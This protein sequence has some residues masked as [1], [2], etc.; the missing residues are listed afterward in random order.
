MEIIISRDKEK[1]RC[2]L[3]SGSGNYRYIYL[4]E[5][6]RDTG[7]LLDRRDFK[8]IKID[9][10]DEAFKEKFVEAYIDLIGKL[11]LEHSSVYWWVTNTAAKNQFASNFFNNLF[12]FY[13]LATKLD[14]N[15]ETDILIINPP[16]EICGSIKK[17]CRSNSINFKILDSRPPHIF[18][19]VKELMAYGISRLYFI[20]KTWEKKY[21]SNKYLKP[22]FARQ[23][24]RHEK[25]YVLRSWFYSSSINEANKY[26][27][28]FFGIL[29]EFL[30]KTG[31]RLL[32]IA[33][34]MGD[35]ESIVKRI[36]SNDHFIVP[37]EFFITYIDPIRAVIDIHFHKIRLKGK[38][39]FNGCDVTDIAHAEIDKEFKSSNI[40][41]NYIFRYYTKRL[42][43]VVKIDTF[44]TTYENRPWER[45]SFQAIREHSPQTYIIGYQHA[46]LCPA[47]VDMR[48]SRHEK[49]IVPVPDKINTIGKVTRDFLEKYGNYVRSKIKESCALRLERPAALDIACRRHSHRLLLIL[50]G[51]LSRAIDMVN[52][53]YR[54][55]KDSEQYQIIIRTHP[56]LSFEQFKS[57][58]DSDISRARNFSISAGTPVKRDLQEADIVIYDASTI[59]IEAV[60][61]GIPVIHIDLNDIL[62]F[63]PLFQCAYL[64]WTV[65]SEEKLRKT[66]E[67]IYQLDETEYY[68]Q[69]TLARQYVQDYVGEVTDERLG[70]FI[71]K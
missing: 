6:D 44:T 17:Y 21:I 25:Y 33:G 52:F 56:A 62:S 41:D 34:I 20:Y 28:S 26:R 46:A 39:D 50:G 9:D 27:D 4:G 66:I 23:F 38:I 19:A 64:K 14:K 10:Y 61:M 53:T 43:N 65:N 5:K 60:M 12:I 42:L 35:Y 15:R 59:S 11:G 7:Q 40:L 36:A 48:L 8:E 30:V 16:G 63:D 68:R 58:L 32:I 18:M 2:F 70:E 3:E 1:L 37:Q 47:F 69:Q 45:V 51:I 55:L 49:D 67:E 31:R 29:P 24:Q 13:T 71:T 54:A 22:K 57:G